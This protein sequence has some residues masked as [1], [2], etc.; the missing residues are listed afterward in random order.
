MRFCNKKNIFFNKTTHIV[1]LLHYSSTAPARNPHTALLHRTQRGMSTHTVVTGVRTAILP[2]VHTP[3][4]G[5]AVV[6]KTLHYRRRWRLVHVSPTT[7][8]RM[9]SN[10]LQLHI[11]LEHFVT[12]CCCGPLKPY[13][14]DFVAAAN[15]PLRFICCPCT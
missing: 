3:R 1:G 2:T 14:H 9:E 4:R 11:I 15:Q 10:S 7:T 13:A 6:Y 5:I 8:T 12:I